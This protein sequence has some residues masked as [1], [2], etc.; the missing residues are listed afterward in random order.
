MT[1]EKLG[2]QGVNYASDYFIPWFMIIYF[3]LLIFCLIYKFFE[4]L[5][6]KIKE[7]KERK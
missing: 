1:I 6:K 4:Y 2:E 5:K 7:K 3:L